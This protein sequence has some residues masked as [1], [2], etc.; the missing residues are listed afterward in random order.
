MSWA[1]FLTALSEFKWRCSV[2]HVGRSHGNSTSAI[3]G[4]AVQVR[5]LVGK[6]PTAVEYFQADENET[7]IPMETT[8][9]PCGRS[10]AR[11]EP[12]LCARDNW[13]QHSTATLYGTRLRTRAEAVSKSRL[14][15]VNSMLGALEIDIEKMPRRTDRSV[16]HPR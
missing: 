6:G 5:R 12:R 7:D 13:A 1:P 15:V 3:C 2:G 14:L 4:P 16:Q 8:T 10:Q 9:V 11:I